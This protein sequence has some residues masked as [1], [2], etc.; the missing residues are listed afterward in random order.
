MDHTRHPTGPIRDCKECRL[1][2]YEPTW[3]AALVAFDLTVATRTA[4]RAA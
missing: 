1:S 3:Y 2:A 4:D